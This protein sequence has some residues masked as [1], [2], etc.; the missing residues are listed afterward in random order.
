MIDSLMSRQTSKH[1]S[2]LLGSPSLFHRRD[3]GGDENKRRYRGRYQNL[4]IFNTDVKS[5]KD[6]RN[7]QRQEAGPGARAGGRAC[8]GVKLVFIINSAASSNP[9]ATF[10][11]GGSRTCNALSSFGATRPTPTQAWRLI[12]RNER[13]RAAFTLSTCRD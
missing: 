2:L 9:V 1:V 4:G 7:G 11:P 10:T 13:G 12:R 6:R 5:I 3:G 8:S